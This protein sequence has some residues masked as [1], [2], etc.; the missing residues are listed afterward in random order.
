M[1]ELP[2]RLPSGRR[3]IDILW[4]EFLGNCADNDEEATI[5][6]FAHWILQVWD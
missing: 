2:I 5:R 1:P 6:N 4:D 3:T